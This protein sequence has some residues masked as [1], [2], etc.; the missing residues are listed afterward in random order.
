MVAPAPTPTPT[1][2]PAGSSPTP[3][4]VLG[5]H[6]AKKIETDAAKIKV[7]FTFSA[8]VPGATFRCKLDKK[9]YAPC[10]SP[11]RLK[12]K[13]GKH[14]FSVVATAAG[15]TDPTPATFKFTVVKN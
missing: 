6:P 15:V 9:A 2:T 14:K 4:T 5:A 7:K 8:D 1:P 12:V 11:K 3:K 10:T 13:A